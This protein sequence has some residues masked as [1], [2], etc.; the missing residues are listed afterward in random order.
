MATELIEYMGK[1]IAL[2]VDPIGNRYRWSFAIDG[3]PLHVSRDDPMPSR[4]A[5]REEGL[6]RAKRI[7]DTG[8]E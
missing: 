4:Q 1:Q 6:M 2:D 8:G 5:M 7:I 3:G